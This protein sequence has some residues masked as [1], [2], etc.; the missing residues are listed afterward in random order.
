LSPTRGRHDFQQLPRYRDGGCGRN[1]DQCR[2]RLGN[3]TNQGN[4]AG[5]Y[6]AGIYLGLG[7]SVTNQA[8]GEAS[9]SF[10]G[11]R[12]TGGAGTVTNAGSV[13]GTTNLGVSLGAGGSLV[14]K[15]GATITG[16]VTGVVLTDGAATVENAGAITS[17]TGAAVS[18]I[19]LT[20]TTVSGTANVLSAAFSGFQSLV[21]DTGAA[22]TV[23]G[24]AAE[25]T[26]ATITGFT[27]ADTIDLTNVAFG[28]TV[29]DSFAAGV[30]SVKTGKAISA[31]LTF[32]GTA[33]S[34]VFTLASDGHGGTDITLKSGTAATP[35]LA[36]QQMALF[37]QAIAGHAT[38]PPTIGTISA[39]LHPSGHRHGPPR[40]APSHRGIRAPLSGRSGCRG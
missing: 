2:Y 36:D 39:L 16:Q 30:L 23:S 13:S 15:A 27:T 3:T 32:A 20:K 33:A 1:G 9:S 29:T 40:R 10:A 25:F 12:V 35:A 14:N 5:T 31:T 19:E 28:S 18:T 7:G 6:S 22:W 21:F 26:P 38:M 11:I 17:A 4:S 24:L 34:P 37:T 8:T